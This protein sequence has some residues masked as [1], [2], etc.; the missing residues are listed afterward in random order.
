MGMTE[1]G[2]LG[3][4]FSDARGINDSGQVVGYST[5]VPGGNFHAFI[6]GTN[7]AGMTDLGTFGGDYS[8]ALEINNSGQV[9]GVF[10]ND[11]EERFHYFITGPNGIG[12]TELPA[13]SFDG[14]KLYSYN[15][16]NDSGQLVGNTFDSD[17]VSAWNMH[18]FFT[19][20]NG[21]GITE[22]SPGPD[23]FGNDFY[24]S[25]AGINNS[26]QVIGYMSED[27]FLYSNGTYADLE[28]LPSVVSG[29]WGSNFNVSDINNNGQIIGHGLHNN[30]SS[31]EAYLLSNVAAP[32]PETEIYAMLLAG[33][34]W[35]GFT[36][37]RRK[38]LING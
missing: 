8:F 31:T 38:R 36:A 28:T 32:V 24:S 6:T 27:T 9:F 33:L 1:L 14:S 11:G 10:G 13:V 26:G 22:L 29:G 2:T 21:I 25:A 23:Q 16:I 20:D 3:G 35:L 7:G 37:Y 5:A 17:G 34:G 18:S 12:M 30:G 4:T 15:G 19:G